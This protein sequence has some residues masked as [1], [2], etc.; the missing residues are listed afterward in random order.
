MN[1]LEMHKEF[2]TENCVR[3]FPGLITGDMETV[4]PTRRQNLSNFIPPDA[5]YRRLDIMAALRTLQPA[6]T[7]TLREAT[8][9]GDTSLRLS[10]SGGNDKD[11]PMQ[12]VMTY[13]GV[14]CSRN[15]ASL[16][17]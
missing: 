14:K 16:T 5:V 6:T 7:L 3:E 4:F 11:V 12:A 17:L 1:L 15:I 9:I 10:P 2:F 8:A 13:D